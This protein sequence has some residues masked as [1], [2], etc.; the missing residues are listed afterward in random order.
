MTHFVKLATSLGLVLLLGPAASA[1][2]GN[3]DEKSARQKAD[4]QKEQKAEDQRDQK[5]DSQT[6]QKSDGQ[7]QD[8]QHRQG[9]G[10]VETIRGELASVSVI[11]ETMVDYSSGRGVVAQLT[12]LTILGSPSGSPGR[13]EGGQAGS[14]PE[15]SKS[16][17]QSGDASKSKSNDQGP[18]QGQSGRASGGRRT[19][20]EVAIT[21][22]TQVRSRAPQGGQGA[23]EKQEGSARQRSQAALE[24]LQLGDRVEV[25]FDR[26]KDQ[27]QSGAGGA[28]QGGSA[29]QSRHGRHRIVRG[30]A[31]SLTILS[32]PEGGDHR[33]TSGDQK[34]D[35]SGKDKSGSDKTQGKSD[36]PK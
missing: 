8:S 16:A 22:E 32:A 24:E 26:F 12:Y 30:L 15:P 6:S 11:G 31:K 4:A 7:E 14:R 23:S 9:S 2:S 17:V 19:V 34:G 33:G 35:S 3:Q 27:G 25:E 29:S 13:G 21:P 10:R 20:Y 28:D 36:S 5:S 18:G 1:Q